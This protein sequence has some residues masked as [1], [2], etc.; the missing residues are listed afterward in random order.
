MK[1]GVRLSDLKFGPIRHPVLPDDFI[2]RIK[3]FKKILSDFDA[4]SLEQTV[5][6]FKRDTNPESELLIWER[7]ANCTFRTTRLRTLQFGRTFL[8][9]F[10][11]PLWVRKKLRTSSI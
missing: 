9:F 3:A 1:V 8:Q 7:I 2:E 10:L 5:D 6:N 11:V 4:V